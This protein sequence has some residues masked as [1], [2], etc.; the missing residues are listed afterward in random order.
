MQHTSFEMHFIKLPAQLCLGESTAA[1]DQ[2]RV[3][4]SG[5]VARACTAEPFITHIY[6]YERDPS[7]VYLTPYFFYSKG[8]II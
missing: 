6:I 2:G 8:K 3:K 4:N 1:S 7:R 5:F